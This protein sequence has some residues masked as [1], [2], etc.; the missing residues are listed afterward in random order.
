MTA[1][2]RG[3]VVRRTAVL[4]VLLAAL[5]ACGTPVDEGPKPQLAGVDTTVGS[6]ASFYGAVV[7]DGAGRTLYQFD[8]DR[9]G[10]PTCYDACQNVWRPYIAQGVPRS[11]YPNVNTI[12]NYL[13][14]LVPRRDGQQQVSYAGHPLYYFAGD[15]VPGDG[16]TPDDI[17]GAGLAQFGGTWAAVSGSGVPVAPQVG[18]IAPS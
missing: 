18:V 7:V 10:R 9:G 12:N 11:T 3:S 15:G 1:T 13:L 17:R 8:G 4:P 6:K 5:A 16:N 2:V 14:D